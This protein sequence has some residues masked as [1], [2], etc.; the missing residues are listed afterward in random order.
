MK[1]NLLPKE[2]RPRKQSAVRPEFIVGL[3]VLLLLGAAG[4]VTLREN[5]RVDHLTMVYEKA[6]SKEEALQ[7]QVQG[8]NRLRQELAELEAREKA[9]QELLAE[10]HESAVLLPSLLEKPFPSLW[11]EALVWES[12]QVEIVGYTK[13]MTSVSRYLNFLN[14]RSEESTLSFAHPA[15]QTDFIIFGIEVKGVRDYG[16]SPLD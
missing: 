2:E 7:A 12:S 8:V 15:E 13:D 4:F 9:Y 1:I 10:E 16:Q 5:A 14:E 11:I 6:L 3:L